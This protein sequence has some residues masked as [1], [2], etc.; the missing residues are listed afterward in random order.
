MQNEC[1]KMTRAPV[2]CAGNVIIRSYVAVAA[3]FFGALCATLSRF[4]P[5]RP[6]STH[7]P[8]HRCTLSDYTTGYWSPSNVTQVYKGYEYCRIDVRQD[9]RSFGGPNATNSNN[10]LSLEWTPQKPQCR[11]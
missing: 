10:Y 11:L 1:P 7:H 3:F 6:L 9:C 8:S 2:S 5:P 4:L